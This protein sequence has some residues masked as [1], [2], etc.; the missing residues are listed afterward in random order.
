ME[1]QVKNFNGKVGYGAVGFKGSG[2]GKK[3]DEVRE[4]REGR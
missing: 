2:K 3:K 1:D 4:G